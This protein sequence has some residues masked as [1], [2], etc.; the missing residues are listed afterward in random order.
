MLIRGGPGVFIDDANIRKMCEW[1][2]YST[3]DNNNIALLIRKAVKESVIYFIHKNN[4]TLL[5]TE[6]KLPNAFE[7]TQLVAHQQELME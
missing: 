4:H 5:I 1:M 2:R 6:S 7:F 3:L